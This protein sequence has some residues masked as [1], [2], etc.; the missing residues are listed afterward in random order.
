MDQQRRLYVFGY[1][2][3]LWSPNFEY[4]QCWVAHLDGYKRRFWL[5]STYA[6]GNEESAGRAATLIPSLEVKIFLLEVF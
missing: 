1:G 2:S 3:I 6:R 5:G 4:T